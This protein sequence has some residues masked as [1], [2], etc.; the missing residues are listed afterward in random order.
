M[1]REKDFHLSDPTWCRGC[2][3]YGIFAALKMAAAELD[4]DPEETVVVTG[5]GCHGRLNNYFLSYGFHALHG[6]TL[7]VAS[8]IKLSNPR[9]SV[10]SISGDGD[11]YSIGV[12]HFVHALRKN[13]DITYLVVDNRLFALTQGQTSPTS[14][15]GYV[16]VSAPF[17]TKELPLDGPRLA[18]ASGGTFIARGFSGQPKK[19][20]TLIEKGIK[21]KGFS[22]IEVLSPC[23]THNKIISAQWFKEHI[24]HL[25]EDQGYDPRDKKLAWEKMIK[26]EKIPVGLIYEEERAAYGELV[27][28]ERNHPLVD[29]DLSLDV[30][31][32]ERILEEYK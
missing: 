18:L 12:G 22:F 16:S 5:I 10:L 3:I 7:P 26:E 1:K 4:L 32:F 27:L 6:R 17:G 13:F 31:R 30:K 11:A 20:A 23:V 8:G 2:G 29:S 21:H 28:P 14:P 24:S 15:L 9:L 25:D 19:L